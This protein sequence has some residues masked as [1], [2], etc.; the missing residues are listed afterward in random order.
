MSLNFSLEGHNGKV[1]ILKNKKFFHEMMMQLRGVRD[2][3]NKLVKCR[4]LNPC[5]NQHRVFQNYYFDFSCHV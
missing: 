2:I 3:L 5:L 4:S 1:A